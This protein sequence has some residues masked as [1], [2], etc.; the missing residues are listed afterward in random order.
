MD[1]FAELMRRFLEIQ[2]DGT[3]RSPEFIAEDDHLMDS[4]QKR[5]RAFVLGLVGGQ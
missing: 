1:R 5:Y 3:P 2:S 4:L